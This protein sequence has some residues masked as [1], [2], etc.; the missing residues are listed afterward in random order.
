MTQFLRHK[1]N[2]AVLSFNENVLASD[3][4]NLEVIEASFPPHADDQLTAEEIVKRD[5]LLAAD[6]EKLRE[7]KLKPAA[8]AKKKAE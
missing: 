8:P 1:T 6:L 7:D 3:P 4:D 5:E 2:G